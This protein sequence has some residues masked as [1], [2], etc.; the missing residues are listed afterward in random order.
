MPQYCEVALPVPLD[1]TF[2]YSVPDSLDIRPGMRVIVPFGPRKLLGVVLRCGLHPEGVPQGLEASAIKPV[3]EALE[4]EPALSAE[5]IRLGKWLSDYYLTPE[6][7]VLGAML[8]RKPPLRSKTRVV[9]TAEGENA[10]LAPES[11]SPP[12]QELMR[13]IA[14]RKGMR[15]ESLQDRAELLRKLRRRGWIATEHTME[16]RTAAEPPA[17]AAGQS[18]GEVVPGLATRH[19]LT[20]RQTEALH[21][22]SQ[23]METGKFAVLLLHGVTGSG[24]TEVY[25]R[26]IELALRRNRSA[27]MLVPEISLTPA[28]AGLFVSRFGSRVAVLHSGMSDAEREAQWH[29]VKKGSSDVVVGTRS[30]VFAPLDRPGLVIVDEEHDSSYKQEESPRYNG[31]DMA[32]VRG[33]EARATVILGSATP[34]IETRYNAEMEK[35]QLLELEYRVRERPLPETSIVDMRQEFAET[36]QKTFFSRRLE[37]EIARRL[38]QREQ[39]LI[40]LNRRGYSAFVLCRSCGQSIQ[41]PNCSIALAHHKRTGR[42]LCHYCGHARAVPRFCPQCKSEHIYFVGEGSERIEEALHR[43]FPQARIGRLDRDTARGR[44]RAEAILAAFRNYELDILVGTQMIAKGHDIHRVTL[45]GVINADIGLAR[46]DF[47]AAER[48]FQLITQVAG[49]AGRGELPGEV[50]IQTFFPD[51]YAI[52]SAAAQ[53]YGMFYQKELRY[54]RMMHYPPFSVLANVIVKSPSSET[55]L[56]LTGRLGRHLEAQ[57]RSGLKLLGPATAP[58]HRLKKDY[59]YHFLIKASRHSIL[60]EVLVSC[61]EFARRENFP[62]TALIIDVDPQSFS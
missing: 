34:A 49:R 10:L 9:L 32:I 53:D 43:R 2:F 62:A 56:K 31:R 17:G 55:A 59:R 3:Q 48:T 8:S 57:Q 18:G 45:V 24:K 5:L 42:L 35:Y 44:G 58:I 19:D 36:G 11:L 13:R 41:C 54:R 26:A 21:S 7:E 60:R 50:I 47:R 27:L 14:R 1:Q 46:P 4:E 33:R 23:K 25:L 38:E 37:E 52:Q 39:N 15:R 29:R 20:P 51:H 6:G 61:R 12:E 40:L 28:M 16:G 22:V 30:A